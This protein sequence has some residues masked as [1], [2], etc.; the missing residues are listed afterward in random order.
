[1]IAFPG[2]DALSRND[3]GFALITVLIMAGML[4]LVGSLIAARTRVYLDLAGGCRQRTRVELELYTVRN[5][6]IMGLTTGSVLSYLISPGG[7]YNGKTW[8][9]YGKSFF[10]EKRVEVSLQD[11]AGLISPFI[12]PVAFFNLLTAQGLTDRDMRNFKDALADWYDK[13]DLHHLNGAENFAYKA[14][15]HPDWPRNGFP[16]LLNEFQLIRGMDKNVFAKVVPNLC[17]SKNSGVNYFTMN[18]EVLQA[19][20]PGIDKIMLADLL[21]RR[22]YGTLSFKDFT[23]A[24]GVGRGESSHLSPNGLIAVKLSSKQT[25]AAYAEEF[26]INIKGDRIHPYLIWEF[27]S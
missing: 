22:D 15:G 21:R 4:F 1:M 7:D 26:L 16:Q 24:T 10:L 17:Y 23:Y 3:K 9:L 6:L 14:D 18:Q 8:N 27:R 2:P 13:D 11:T 12:Q 25:R 19:S 5:K 20:L